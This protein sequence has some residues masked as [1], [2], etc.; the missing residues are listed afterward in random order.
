MKKPINELRGMTD[1]IATALKAQ[2][3]HDSEQLLAAAKTP[4]QRKHLAKEC[5]CDEREILELAN[6]SDL[7]RLK[8]IG[9]AYSDLL[10]RAGVDTVK[11][12]RHR[13]PDNLHAKMVEVN[14]AEAVVKQ[15]PTE[16]DVEDWVNQAKALEP[17]IEY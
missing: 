1:A 7:A 16:A 12:L 4:T 8:G 9:G 17:A 13:R 5:G 15:L 11:E 2:G 10:E 6:R 3:I 14:A